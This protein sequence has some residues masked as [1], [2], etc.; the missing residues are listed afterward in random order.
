MQAEADTGASSLQQLTLQ[1]CQRAAQAGNALPLVDTVPP[2]ALRCSRELCACKLQT[3]GGALSVRQAAWMPVGSACLHVAARRSRNDPRTGSFRAVP[4]A[5]L[6]MSLASVTFKALRSAFVPVSL[7]SF[8]PLAFFSSCKTKTASDPKLGVK[9]MSSGIQRLCVTSE[10]AR[11]R[12]PDAKVCSSQRPNDRTDA[13]LSAESVISLLPHM[14]CTAEGRAGKGASKAISE[15]QAFDL[16][17][18]ASPGGTRSYKCRAGAG[19]GCKLTLALCLTNEYA[20]PLPVGSPGPNISRA[21]KF[22]VRF[23]LRL[24]R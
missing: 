10:S 20:R 12:V 1:H 24:L 22:W 18:L 14:W 23:V 8:L 13:E 6:S 7:A 11:Q 17:P 5:H 15:A 16:K 3:S 4:A 9:G 2:A 21:T 19:E